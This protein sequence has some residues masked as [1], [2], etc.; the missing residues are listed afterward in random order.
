MISFISRRIAGAGA[1]CLGLTVVLFILQHMSAVDPVRILVGP[2]A[3]QSVV[4]E[5]RHRLGYDQPLVVQWFHYL[6][7]LVTGNLQTSLR[8]QRPV[9]TD[10]GQYLPA[11]I[12]LAL[13][14]IVIATVLALTLGLLTAARKKGSGLFSGGLLALSS[15]P[16]FLLALLAVLLFY[17]TLHW[18]PA[19]GRISVDNPPTG[20]TGLLTVDGLLHGRLDATVDAVR[21]LILPATCLA[22]LPAVAVGR[23]LRSSL[24]TAMGSEYV[25]TARAKGMSNSRILF[26][27]GLRNSAVTP[28]SM[29]GLQ[30]GT[31]F[32]GLVIVETVFAWPGIGLYLDQ[33]IPTADF[34]AIAGTTLLLGVGYVL[35]NT[36]VDIIQTVLDPRIVR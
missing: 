13:F 23:V 35:A 6:Q 5:A 1:V 9:T 4:E 7:G 18:L 21:H 3:P 10:L 17:S 20:P 8:T 19:T 24:T 14:A 16:T 2:S 12:E 22:M 27:H 36:A 25:R 33:S 28:L 30:L 15:A 26:R 34:P 32:A 31:L 29:A 11:S